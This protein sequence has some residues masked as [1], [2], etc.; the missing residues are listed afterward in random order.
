[1]ATLILERVQNSNRHI[2]EH[3]GAG[4]D[5]LVADLERYLAFEDVE[6]LFFPA[7]DVGGGPPP[8]GTMAS[9][10]A[11]LPLVSSPVARKR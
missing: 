7:V 6:A 4:N 10:W 5:P 3:S 11:Y 8:G 9:H 1:L 2:C